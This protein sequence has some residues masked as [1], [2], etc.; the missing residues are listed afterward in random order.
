MVKGA[1]PYYKKKQYEKQGI[2]L[3]T[4]KTD[5]EELRQGTVDYIGFS[6]YMSNVY[7]ADESN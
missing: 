5:E 7:C 1:Y 6:Y 3:E 2:L 4:E